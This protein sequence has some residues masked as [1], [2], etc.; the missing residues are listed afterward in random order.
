V[1]L[2]GVRSGWRNL[3]ASGKCGAGGRFR[4]L[5]TR[6]PGQ[7]VPTRRAGPGSFHRV[8][9]ASLTSPRH[10]APTP[11]AAHSARGETGPGMS[12]KAATEHPEA[13]AKG[14]GGK[15]KL[16]LLAVPLLLTA[17]GAGLW[18]GGFLPP[19][20]GMGKEAH[21][22]A[23]GEGKGA[24]APTPEEKE[25]AAK[26]P[27][28]MDLPDIVANLNAGPR[29]TGF[30]K[31]HVKLE[32]ERPEDVAIA[33]AALP[34]LLDLFQ[35]YMRDMRPEELKGAAGMYRLREELIARANIAVTPAH[36]SDVLFT[37]MLVQ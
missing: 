37:E 6:T 21:A 24:D 30:V 17:I 9:K 11:D 27:T 29:R 28:F 22:A 13:P 10:H 8:G 34:R 12:A 16:I 23:A 31:V 35:T 14:D 1:L 4:D 33:T 20:L 25:E 15:K 36:V 26:P 2:H 7:I 18:F 3:R 32:L 5:T 19:L